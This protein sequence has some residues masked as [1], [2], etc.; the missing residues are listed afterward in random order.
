MNKNLKE[1]KDELIQQ[2]KKLEEDA[3]T[4]L[5]MAK[6][7]YGRDRESS[8]KIQEYQRHENEQNNYIFSNCLLYRKNLFF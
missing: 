3:R 7:T 8:R 4:N 1:D 5:I 2:K 6:E